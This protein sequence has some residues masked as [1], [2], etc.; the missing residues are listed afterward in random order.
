MG[1]FPFGIPYGWYPVAWSFELARGQVAKRR[2]FARELVLFRGESGAVSVL[3]AHCPHLGAHLGV[4]GKV[5]GDSLR[6]PFHGWRFAGSGECV[7]IPYANRKPAAARA[8]AYPVRESG[9]VVWAWYHPKAAA[10]C[11]E[12]PEIPE[13]G[14]PDWMSEWTPY[15]WTVRTHPQEVAENSVDWPHFHEIH[16]MEPPPER[17]V[18]FE[19]HEIRWHAA[20]TKNVATLD[21]ASDS[22]RVVGRNPGLGCSYVR[23][24]G[25]G[26]SV[27]VMGMTPI[28]GETMHMR[29]G[30]I[31]KKNGRSDDEMAAFHKAYADDMA[32]AVEQDFPIWE[33]KVYHAAPRLCDG[34][35]PV[36][37]F[38]RWAA[39]FYV[40]DDAR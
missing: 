27:I 19:G 11:F 2:Y 16:H 18:R 39:Q 4:G 30:V 14:A 25:L 12:P 5:E 29:F 33:N 17:D 15:D 32:R 3:A 40:A 26:D 31:G 23:Y 20:T 38:R 22:I 9:G 37:E 13:F 24:S 34:D 8:F 6:C 35:G 28:D 7:E 36:P 10:P 1:R 21:G